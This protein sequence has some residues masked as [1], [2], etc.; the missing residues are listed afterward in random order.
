MPFALLPRSSVPPASRPIRL[1]LIRFDDEFHREMPWPKLP[2]ITLP[3]S[4]S[5]LPSRLLPTVLALDMLVI[6]TPLPVL[7]STMLP[8]A[9]RP[10]VLPSTQL[11]LA[12]L[13]SMPSPPLPAITLRASALEPPIVVLLPP[14]KSRMPSP[15]LPKAA[16]PLALTPM[17]LPWIVLLVV[18][19]LALASTMMPRLALPEITLPAPATAPP[20]SVPETPS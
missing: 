20:I 10:M 12:L 2:A 4:A 8:P 16:L 19:A 6:I 9:S 14:L 11:L 7:A 17:W 1:P 15:P 5:L 18:A 13:I 3:S